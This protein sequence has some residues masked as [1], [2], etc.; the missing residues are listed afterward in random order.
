MGEMQPVHAS[1]EI[2]GACCA[3]PR[4]TADVVN[5]PQRSYEFGADEIN[6]DE[7]ADAGEHRRRRRHEAEPTAER[8]SSAIA[9]A[10]RDD[11]VSTGSGRLLQGRPLGSA[12]EA[13]A[14]D[15]MLP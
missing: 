3:A 13:K 7:D 15:S 8:G 5:A 9:S 10:I 1:R 12:I 2:N 4:F 14:I 11:E 6:H